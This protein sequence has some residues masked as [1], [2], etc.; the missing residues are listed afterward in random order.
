MGPV[1]KPVVRILNKMYVNSCTLY[2]Q[3]GG[4]IILCRV[5]EQ[6]SIAERISAAILYNPDLQSRF[7]RKLKPFNASVPIQ[8][9]VTE[10]TS[11]EEV[12]VF[13]TVFQNVT[14]TSTAKSFLTCYQEEAQ[15]RKGKGKSVATEATV[16][17]LPNGEEV[18]IIDHAQLENYFFVEVKFTLNPRTKQVMH[19]IESLTSAVN[20]L[21][22]QPRKAAAAGEGAT[23]NGDAAKTAGSGRLALNTKSKAYTRIT[24]DTLV[25]GMSVP[26]MTVQVLSDPGPVFKSAKGGSLHKCVV[27]DVSGNIVALF[28]E[29]VSKTLKKG[30]VVTVANSRVV[31]QKGKLQLLVQ[32]TK[33]YTETFPADQ[34]YAKAVTSRHVN[35]RTE[36]ARS[37]GCLVFRGSKVIMVRSLESV[38]EGMSLPYLPALQGESP[39]AAAVRAT[40]LLCDIN[41]EEFYVSHDIAPITI[42]LT[43]GTTKAGSQVANEVVTLFPAFAT[44]PPPADAPPDDVM[45]P[46]DEEDLYDWYT[47]P[48]AM[49][50]LEV[51]EEKRAL[52]TMAKNLK[53]A[54]DFGV[55]TPR[56]G[57]LFGAAYITDQTSTPAA[58]SGSSSGAVVPTEPRVAYTDH[59]LAIEGTKENKALKAL[60]VTVLSGFLGAGKTTLLQHILNNREGL[61]V[62]VIVN[63]MSEV[64]I[65]AMLVE[66]GE[67]CLSR[68]DEKMVEMS[69]GC[70]CCTLREDLLE[71]ITTLALQGKFDYLLIESSGISEP[72]PVAETFTFEDPVTGASLSDI[73]MLD[74]MVTVIDSL[75]FIRDF[76]GRD[77][78]DDREMAAYDGDERTIVDLL[79]DQVEFA[80]VIILNKSGLLSEQERGQLRAKVHHLNPDARLI[81]TNYSKVELKQIMGTGLFSFEKAQ[82]APGWLKEIR[83]EHIPETIEYGIS[84]FVFHQRRPFHPARLHNLI[85]NTSVMD[86]VYRSKGFCWI[87]THNAHN[88]T[89]AHA[90]RLYKF[91]ISGQWWAAIDKAE[92]PED[93]EEV[94]AADW[95]PVHG[96]RHQQVV[97]IG[98]H[99]DKDVVRN[100]LIECLLTDEEMAEG[101]EAWVAYDD[102]IEVLVEDDHH[103]GG[104]D[105]GDDG[106]DH[107]DHGHGHGH[108]H[109]H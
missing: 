60:P 98:A 13:T 69:N 9:F 87:A 39:Q 78:L 82:E 86:C 84:S 85:Y 29:A 68:Q 4:A 108:G 34:D 79:T 90:G 50:R 64:N 11:M 74:T 30:D 77:K 62:A 57:A 5:L 53:A 95:D 43:N 2:A 67:A 44:N 17:V 66:K 28:S 41:P 20:A 99:M 27:G 81:E 3:E 91:T 97:V 12:S 65:D 101:P 15:G 37:Y 10:S 22:P 18:Y 56:Y 54:N 32:A 71:E 25:G 24:V 45:E 104:A 80:N 107:G 83:G 51:D 73:A 93:V 14:V 72:L 36:L 35:D 92:W 7:V 103:G 42:Y 31:T 6:Q 52:L 46:E 58:A 49:R 33:P 40:C 8:C 63:D 76:E 105:G 94:V 59:F 70:I 89:W 1:S 100:A 26:D 75:N 48:F 106:H 55:Y 47:Y 88:I 23:G 21:F 109:A 61:K 16:Q 96:D 38:W 102:P 19:V